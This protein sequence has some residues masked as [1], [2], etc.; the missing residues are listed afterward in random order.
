MPGS[1]L[2]SNFTAG[3]LSPSLSARVELAKYNAGC[4]TL[5]NFL[6]QAHGGAVKRPGF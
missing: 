5:R 3:E 1:A 4:R 6:V 2:Q